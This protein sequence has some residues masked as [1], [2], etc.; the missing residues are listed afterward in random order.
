MKTDNE[1]LSLQEVARILGVHPSTVRLWSNKGVLPVHRTQGGHRRYKRS[2]VALWAETS[3]KSHP[4]E[5]QGIIQSAVKNVRLQIAEGRLEAE[6]WYQRLD[7]EARIQYRQSAH[8]LF[9][10]L[11]NYLAASGQDAASEA[12]AIGYEYASR[13]RHYNLRSA[14]A[15]RA[16]LFFRNILVESVLKLYADANAQTGPAIELFHKMQN[17]T[18]EILV[19]LLETYQ[20]LEN[21]KH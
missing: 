6:P 3:Q 14:D 18:D 10:G 7:E 21:S 20:A 12:Y 5:P 17:F 13:A 15:V 1:W 11:M 8:F 19:T 2:E 9:R 16:F 4:L